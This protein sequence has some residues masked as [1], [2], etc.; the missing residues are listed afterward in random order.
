MTLTKI[1]V[2]TDQQC[3]PFSDTSW[4]PEVQTA[5][6]VHCYWALKLTTKWTEWDLSTSLQVLASCLDPWHTQLAPGS[7]LSLTLYH[8][9]KNLKKAKHEADKLWKA[10]LDALLN[11]AITTNQQKKSKA[12]KYL[13]HAEQNQLCYAQFHHHTKPKSAGGLAFVM[14]TTE[15]GNKK[16]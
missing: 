8:A 14:I 13:I 5:Y 16:P 9:Q 12:L 6:L 15:D 1:L 11:Q 7:T 10:H 4:S 2:S 3:W